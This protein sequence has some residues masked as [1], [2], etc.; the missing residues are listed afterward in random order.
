MMSRTFPMMC[1]QTVSLEAIVSGLA[2]GW[3]SPYLA[4]LTSAEADIPLKLTDTEASWVAS[5][6]NLGRL[7]GALLGAL[8]Q[9]KNPSPLLPLLETRFINHNLERFIQINLFNSA[10]FAA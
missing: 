10:K 9:G 1:C 2:T 4:Q 3:A 8:C 7:I 5:L 6:L